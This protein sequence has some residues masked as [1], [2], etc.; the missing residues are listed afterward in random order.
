MRHY[1]RNLILITLLFTISV[2]ILYFADSNS[3]PVIK[4]IIFTGNREIS[5]EIHRK[6]SGAMLVKEKIEY[7]PDLLQKSIKL[8][9]L[10]GFFNDINAYV[11][12]ENDGVQIKFDF[13]FK[14][15]I[16]LLDIKGGYD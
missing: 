5:A 2:Q 8:L 10:L 7:S 9:Y 13:I 1:N 4:K 3:V 16:K 15:T 11:I 6:I 12:V 14:T